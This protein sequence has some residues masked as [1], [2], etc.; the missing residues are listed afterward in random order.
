MIDEAIKPGHEI[1]LTVKPE[2]INVFTAD[3]SRNILTG[4]RNDSEANEGA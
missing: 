1:Y 3:G 2:K 4:V